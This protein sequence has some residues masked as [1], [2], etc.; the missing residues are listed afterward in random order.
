MLNYQY[1]RSF[2]IIIFIFRQYNINWSTSNLFCNIAAKE[3][4]LRVL[5]PKLL[6]DRFDMGGKTRNIAIQLV[7]LVARQVA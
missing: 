3:A 1:F 2:I 7:L 4:M 6:Q 5:P